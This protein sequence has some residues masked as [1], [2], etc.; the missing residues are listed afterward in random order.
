MGTEENKE[1]VRRFYTEAVNAQN[2]DVV[3]ALLTEDF[4]HNGERRGRSGQK[5]VVRAFL[6]GFPDLHDEIEIIVAEGD[7][8]AVHHRWTGTH[9]GVFNGVAP[10]GRQVEFVSTAILQFR[11]G[12]IAVATDVVGMAELMAQLRGD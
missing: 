8:V 2:V 3:D 5:E 10:T 7:L 4:T 9:K 1:V 12:Q 6:T 11:D